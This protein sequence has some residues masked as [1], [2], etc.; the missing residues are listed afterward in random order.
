MPLINESAF[1]KKVKSGDASGLYF[2]FG[3]E[4]YL[5]KKYLN[6]LEEAVLSGGR[7]SFNYKVLDEFNFNLEEMVNF[8]E[9]VP[10]CCE[11]KLLKILNFNPSFLNKNDL[12]KFK[13]FVLNLPEYVTVAIAQTYENVDLKLGS[14][15]SV[16]KFFEKYGFVLKA[17]KFSRYNLEEAVEAWAKK[18]KTK[19]DANCVSAIV[20]FCSDDLM[21]L[22]TEFKKIL[23]YS[24][25]NKV[26]CADIE[27]IVYKSREAGVFELTKEMVSGNLN[28]VLCKLDLLLLKKEEPVFIL[29]VIAS[30]YVDV[31]R[32]K[33]SSIYAKNIRDLLTIFNYKGKEFRLDI[34]KRYANRFS[35]KE[36]K[37]HIE[38]ITGTDLKLKTTNLNKRFLLE[39]LLV[40][41]MG[42]DLS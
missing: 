7:N 41:I 25:T 38:L 21:S 30:F 24:L 15:L 32:V 18:E 17:N 14:W 26:T 11:R 40:V 12:E 35:L 29:N 31:Y 28:R 36:I 16:Y 4:K 8:I 20:N 22:D 3:L 6:K 27:N 33:V 5:V 19:I 37:N 2:I 10:F 23:A 1:L 13:G 9:S 39:K 42:K 34:A